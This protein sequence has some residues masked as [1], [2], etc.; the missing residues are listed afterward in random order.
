MRLGLTA[1]LGGALP[2]ALLL[3][4]CSRPVALPDP[5]P[6]GADLA[7]C[8]ALMADLP[9]QVLDQERRKAE[10]G[11]FSAAWG[12]PA[13]TLRCGV[14]K[15]P[16]LGPA[17]TCLEANGVGWF[18][19]E[20]EGGLLFTTIGR[21]TYVELAVPSAYAPESGALVDVAATVAAHNRLLSPCV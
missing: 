5:A 13:I 21:Q 1:A 4:G 19:E 15:P 18:T 20:A 6:T 2:L 8:T 3:G 17:S 14:S 10:P 9:E 11:V 16:E 12:D 7:T